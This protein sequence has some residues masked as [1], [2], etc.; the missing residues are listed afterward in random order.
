MG[1]IIFTSV[2]TDAVLSVANANGSLTL[3]IT[4]EFM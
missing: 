3:P 1:F 4:F 2:K